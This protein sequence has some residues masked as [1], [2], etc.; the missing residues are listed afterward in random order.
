[1]PR[2]DGST[3]RTKRK[4]HLGHRMHRRTLLQRRTP[5]RTTAVRVGQPAWG[6]GFA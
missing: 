3:P 4:K 5:R 6:R 2:N 1:M